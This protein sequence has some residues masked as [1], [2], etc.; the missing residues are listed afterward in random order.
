MKIFTLG[1]KLT[2]SLLYM[3]FTSF[4]LLEAVFRFLPVSESVQ[5]QPVTAKSPIAHFR[6]NRVVTLQIGFDFSHVVEKRINN[7]GFMSDT[8]FAAERHPNVGRTVII[9]DSFVEAF[10]VTNSK[11]FHGIISKAVKGV[12]VY[13]IGISGAPLSQYLAYAEFAEQT[14]NPDKYVFV[15]IANDFDESLLKNKAAPPHHYFTSSGSLA[16]STF[17]PNR[18]A[19]IVIKSAFIRYLYFDLKLSHR[20][21]DLLRKLG[22]S[23]DEEHEE[24]VPQEQQ[25]RDDAFFAVR[26][27][28]KILETKVQ[29]KPVLLVL[30]GDRQAIYA[31]KTS[32]RGNSWW[33]EAF[34]LI[35][36]ESVNYP[37]VQ[38]LDLHPIFFERWKSTQQKFEYPYD[39]HWNERGHEVVAKAILETSFIPQAPPSGKST[40]LK[41][42]E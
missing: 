10:Q 28:L 9:G 24:A 2:V 18:L 16:L 11:T 32:E 42:E 1:K 21:Q 23:N 3:G 38:I 31:N 30:D 8:D 27:F 6:E 7:F 34:E 20:L 37:N 26:N 29:G 41:W 19:Q 40:K 12:E 5:I 39:S 13:P 4:L 35:V 14:F 36:S 22:N 33:S 15:I 17:E 25:L